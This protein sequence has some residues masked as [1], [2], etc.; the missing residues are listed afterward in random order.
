M[1]ADFLSGAQ[2][3]FDVV[4]HGNASKKKMINRIVFMNLISDFVQLLF[5]GLL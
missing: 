4:F 3:L 5:L 2:H 1:F